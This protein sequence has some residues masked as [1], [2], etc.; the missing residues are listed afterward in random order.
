MLLCDLKRE[1]WAFNKKIKVQNKSVQQLRTDFHR[2]GI[3]LLCGQHRHTSSWTVTVLPFLYPVLPFQKNQAKQRMENNLFPILHLLSQYILDNW[4]LSWNEHFSKHIRICATSKQIV[5]PERG[6]Q[7][8]SHMCLV[9]A[10]GVMILMLHRPTKGE[11]GRI[12]GLK[13]LS[14]WGFLCVEEI[15]IRS[16]LCATTCEPTPC[17]TSSFTLT[18]CYHP[19]SH[20]SPSISDLHMLLLLSACALEPFHP[21][22]ALLQCHHLQWTLTL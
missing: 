17:L 5:H 11:V 18:P 12:W 7:E 4:S 2:L 9:L 14:L 8:I 22:L 3:R 20:A 6:K 16:P 13:S 1:K 21:H 10:S 15:T 19:F